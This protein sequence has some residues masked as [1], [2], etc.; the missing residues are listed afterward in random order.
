MYR[1]VEKIFSRI[2]PAAL[3]AACA[4]ALLIAGVA[5]LTRPMAGALGIGLEYK[6]GTPDYW[7]ERIQAVGASAAYD[8]FAESVVDA[9]PTA[10]HSAA[11]YFGAALYAALGLEGLSVCDDRYVWG[12]FHE[13]IGRVISERGPSVVKDLTAQ[14]DSF[15][16]FHRN[17]CLHGFGHALQAWFGY[18][19]ADLVQALEA[20]DEYVPGSGDDLM[21]GCY[22]GVFMEFDMRTMTGLGPEG[23]RWSEPEEVYVLCASVPSKFRPTCAASA[24]QSWIISASDPVFTPEL[25]GNFGALCRGF[26]DRELVDDCYLGLGSHL[27]ITDRPADEIISLCSAISDNDRDRLLCR[28]SSAANSRITREGPSLEICEGLADSALGYCRAYATGEADYTQPTPLPE[29]YR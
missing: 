29:E 25:F 18:E 24:V 23:Y 11:H 19:H 21:N 10:Q 27:P 26:G 2:P 7:K 8:E 9:A 12:C 3:F 22:T 28:G 20:C 13:L 4:A 14:C 1:R 15:A 5:S 6:T 17:E 16:G